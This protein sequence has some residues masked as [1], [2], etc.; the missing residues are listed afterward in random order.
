MKCFCEDLLFAVH[1]QY[2]LTLILKAARA[3]RCNN[4]EGKV[5]AELCSEYTSDP[6]DEREIYEIHMFNT[7]HFVQG[8][9]IAYHSILAPETFCIV[10]A[11]I[12]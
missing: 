10:T 7:F 8:I 4:A 11:G 6:G 2:L 9:C 3:A 5:P 1:V 12:V